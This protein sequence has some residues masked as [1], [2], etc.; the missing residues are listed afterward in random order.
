MDKS[1]IYKNKTVKKFNN[2]RNVWTGY[3][4]EHKDYGDIKRKV[5]NII[6]SKNFIYSKLVHIVIDGKV[7]LKKIVGLYGDNIITIE[8]EYISIDN[9]DDIYI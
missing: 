6:N 2:N 1:E 8:N 7:L 9:I 3:I 5:L 4:K